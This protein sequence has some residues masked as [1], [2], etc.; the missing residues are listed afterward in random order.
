MVSYFHIFEMEKGNPAK[1][2]KEDQGA[3]PW[4]LP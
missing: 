2:K 3:K 1:R 4:Q